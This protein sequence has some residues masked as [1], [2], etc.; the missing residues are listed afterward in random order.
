MSLILKSN[1][2]TAIDP[3]FGL[4]DAYIQRVQIDGGTVIDGDLLLNFINF[5]AEKSIDTAKLFSVISAGFG[6]KKDANGDIVKLYSLFNS[7]GDLT[8]SIGGKIQ[9]VQVGEHQAIS[10]N[11]TNV[12]YRSTGQVTG[13]KLAIL[14]SFDKSVS[15]TTYAIADFYNT[16]G[17]SRAMAAQT[18]NIAYSG[19]TAFG[20]AMTGMP[21]T[22]N[23]GG[24]IY[25]GKLHTIR[26]G[27]LFASSGDLSL[28][29]TDQNH[30]FTLG[31]YTTT[32][33]SSAQG[34][35]F[36]TVGAINLTIEEA[37]AINKFMIDNF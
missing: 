32:G 28:P 11:V 2:D 22:K 37:K 19:F 26:D 20:T 10:S 21:Y 9:A 1:T 5:V 31:R 27:R 13:N 6:I 29:A 12:S 4:Y 18:V 34:K 33:G 35:N 7:A 25:E 14:S 3:V 30:T 15:D 24:V 16:V 17:A 36:M 23:I 8:Y